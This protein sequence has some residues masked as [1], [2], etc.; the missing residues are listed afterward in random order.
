LVR[1]ALLTLSPIQTPS[2]VKIDV[3]NQ[4]HSS[5]ESPWDVHHT[6]IGDGAW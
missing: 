4:R 1:I 3:V 6:A 5:H 2:E